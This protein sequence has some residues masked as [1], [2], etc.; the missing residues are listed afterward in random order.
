MIK[1]EKNKKEKEVKEKFKYNLYSGKKIFFVCLSI[2]FS[3]LFITSII[4]LEYVDIISSYTFDALFGYYC[5]VFYVLMIF[6]CL[7]RAFNIGSKLKLSLDKKNKINLSFKNIVIISFLIIIIIDS[8]SSWITMQKLFIGID[9][10]SIKYNEWWN[11]FSSSGDWLNVNNFNSGILIIFITTFFE[12][13]TSFAVLIIF[14]FIALFIQIITIF[15]KDLIK[16]VLTIKRRKKKE[17]EQFN[18]HIN[19]VVDPSN[20]KKAAI[21]NREDIERPKKFEDKQTVNVTELFPFDD[22]FSKDNLENKEWK[23]GVIDINEEETK[24]KKVKRNYVS[25]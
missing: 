16:N 5:Y 17:W 15:K 1:K 18:K 9:L 8:F 23:T 24:N 10:W 6:Y 2:F 14:C 13:W 4:N 22:P 11:S 25:K 21:A 7:D 12:F 19:N 3:F 20:S